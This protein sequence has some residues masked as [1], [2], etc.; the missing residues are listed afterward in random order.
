[1]V[2]YK[3]NIGDRLKNDKRDLTITNRKIVKKN[4]VS[5]DGKP[6]IQ[7]QVFYQFICNK[8]GFDSGEYYKNGVHYDE[9]WIVQGNLINRGDGCP[10]CRNVPQI[11]VPH[12]N[13][14]VSDK[15]TEWMIPYFQGG[16]DEA[17]MYTKCS[18]Q[19]LNFVCQDCHKIKD[20]KMSVNHLYRHKSC[21]CIC[22]DGISYPNKYGYELFNN[23][24]SNQIQNFS[25]E[26]QPEW[27]KPYY[28]DF[29]FEKDGRS[30]ICEF[31]GELGHGK[32]IHKSS[33]KTVE[34]TIL[35][36]KIKEGLAKEHNINL[37]R[38]DASISS[39]DY[40][41]RSILNSELKNIVDL[42]SVDFSKCDEF[43]CSNLVKTV[44]LDYENNLLENFELSDKYHLSDTTI[45]SY[46]KHGRNIGWVQRE[47]IRKYRTSRKGIATHERKV[48]YV[49]EN[50]IEEYYSSAKELSKISLDKF[51]VFISA[52][53]IRQVCRGQTIS[54]CG[55]KGFSYA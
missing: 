25:R 34:E 24:L 8:C 41:S 32:E 11:T 29:Y 30:Y 19:K 53:K 20:K 48:K 38:V 17:K 35:I 9:Y 23:Q 12:I 50:G 15:E 4:Y 14:I 21:Q 54:T 16:Y 37:I 2:T 6:F 7:N 22:G 52:S 3:L 46:L 42:S 26:Y 49:D 51:G 1:M 45:C 39:S 40:I 31:D 27:A 28:Y 43:S 18:N 44:C 36:D 13:S 5:K 55:I 33:N 10:C 47:H